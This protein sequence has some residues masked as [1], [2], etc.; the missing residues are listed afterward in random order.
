M[1][2]HDKS[3]SYQNEVT[4]T[5][6]FDPCCLIYEWGHCDLDFWPQRS[7]EEETYVSV[8]ISIKFTLQHLSKKCVSLIWSI[9]VIFQHNPP[10]FRKLNTIFLFFLVFFLDGIWEPTSL[11]T[12]ECI[13]RVWWSTITNCLQ[14]FLTNG[15][16]YINKQ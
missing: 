12:N 2:G 9:L 7:N 3:V 1:I 15:N 14:I 6:T 13:Y 4:V 8:L 5:L 11:D 16:T 10:E